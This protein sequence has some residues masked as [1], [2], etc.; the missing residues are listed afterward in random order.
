MIQTSQPHPVHV[1]TVTGSKDLPNEL[2]KCHKQF[3]AP[4]PAAKFGW[5][6]LLAEPLSC[7]WR[8]ISEQPGA[9]GMIHCGVVTNLVK[10]ASHTKRVSIILLPLYRYRKRL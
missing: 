10:H 2:P 6:P 1:L 8:F 9:V 5:Q 7:T 3:F 4:R